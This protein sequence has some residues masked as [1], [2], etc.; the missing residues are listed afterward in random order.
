MIGS[1]GF[2]LFTGYTWYVCPLDPIQK[3]L[4]PGVLLGGSPKLMYQFPVPNDTALL[5]ITDQPH[6]PDLPAGWD[7]TPYKV[8][9]GLTLECLGYKLRHV[10]TFSEKDEETYALFAG[11]VLP[12]K[13]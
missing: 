7:A 13:V 8:P 9:D 12:P 10:H 5:V 11:L 4:K 3:G 1:V 6:K 2:Q